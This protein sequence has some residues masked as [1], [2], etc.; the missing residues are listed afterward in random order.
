MIGWRARIGYIC[1]CPAEI[2]AYLFYRIVPSG[3]SMV[4]SGLSV[5]EIAEENLST[6]I[7]ESAGRAIQDMAK[8]EVDFIILAGEPMVFLKG[9]G[10]EQ[11]LNEQAKVLTSTPFTHNLPCAVEALRHLN[12]INIS[13]ATP[14]IV[15]DEK[16]QDVTY[17]KWKAYL[18]AAGFNLVSFKTFGIQSNREVSRLPI[19]ASFRLAREAYSA[20][21]LIPD[22]IYIPCAGWE[23]P[24]NISM[25]E[26]D[27]DV[28]VITSL[29]ASIWKA[30]K[31]LHI[32]EV[33]PEYG[34]L[35]EGWAKRE[36]CLYP[37]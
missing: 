15:R 34:R 1:P 10:S 36:K 18:H 2:E 17:E 33:Q 35:F 5:Q 37:D 12:A 13:I 14:Y 6:A 23:A 8:A 26:N 27:L 28:P 22:A 7:S 29:Q 20:A 4:V 25:L 11:S 16:G 9:Y 21:E 31:E 3:V 24:L 19:D 32:Q 30:L